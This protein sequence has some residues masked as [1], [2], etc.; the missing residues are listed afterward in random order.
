M[1]P[2]IFPCLDQL[3]VHLEP[4]P[5][6]EPHRAQRPK[7]VIEERLAGRQGGSDQAESEVGRA[8]PRVVLDRALVD[9]VEQ[10]VDREISAAGDKVKLWSNGGAARRVRGRGGGGGVL[11]GEECG[12][13][14]EVS[15]LS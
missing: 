2:G 14:A 3:R 1:H 15:L 8:F 6:R 4:K 5:A 12:D 13:V 7:G 11:R 10:G 9:V